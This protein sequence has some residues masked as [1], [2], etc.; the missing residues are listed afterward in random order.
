MINNKE[1]LK[2]IIEFNKTTFFDN[3]FKMMRMSQEQGEKMLNTTL[4]QASWLPPEGKKA[5]GEWVRSYKKGV[6]EF[7]SQVDEQY[8]KVEAFLSK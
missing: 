5:I 7:K 2:Q 8:K 4:D 1:M 3:A 6:D